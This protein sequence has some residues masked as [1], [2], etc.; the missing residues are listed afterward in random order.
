MVTRGGGRCGLVRNSG[1]VTIGGLSAVFCNVVVVLV[2]VVV[3]VV[4]VGVDEDDLVVSVYIE[5]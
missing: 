4:V 3:A 2:A 1:Y 5:Y